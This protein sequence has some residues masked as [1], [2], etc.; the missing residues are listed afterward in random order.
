MIIWGDFQGLTEA[1]GGGGLKKTRKL[2]RRR[3]WMV[4]YFFSLFR[5]LH[6]FKRIQLWALVYVQLLNKLYE[7]EVTLREQKIPLKCCQPLDF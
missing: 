7:S 4:P 1:T 5:G 6:S 2:R 3:L